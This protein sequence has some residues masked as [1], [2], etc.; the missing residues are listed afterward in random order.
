VNIL[1]S[2]YADWLSQRPSLPWNRSWVEQFE[3][4]RLTTALASEIDRTLS[5]PIGSLTPQ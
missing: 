5:A 2:R 3:R 1:R 4:R